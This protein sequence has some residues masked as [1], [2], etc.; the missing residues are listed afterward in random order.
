MPFRQ[1]D[2]LLQAMPGIGRHYISKYGTARRSFRL[3]ANRLGMAKAPIYVHWLSTYECNF[4]CLHCEADAGARRGVTLETGHILRAVKDMG[5]M[6]VRT[7]II[8]GGEPLLRGDIFEVFDAAKTAGIPNLSLATNGF[9]VQD[10]RDELKSAGL[11]TVH[12]SIDGPAETND[13]T[14]GK[15]DASR[16]AWQ[17]LAFFKKIGVRNRVLNTLVHRGNIQELNRFAATVF[18][19]PATAWNI[20]VPL[21]KGR[22]SRHTVMHLTDED[23]A[24]LFGFMLEAG[25]RFPV[26]MAETASFLGPL[27]RRLRPQPFFC[28]AGIETC[29]I[30]P[31]G[32]VLGCHVLYDNAYSEGNIKE[33][34][35]RAIWERRRG[36]FK[37]PELHERC[38]T[39]PQLPACRGGCMARRACDRPCLREVWEKTPFPA[40]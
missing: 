24:V 40:R 2:K 30:M 5:G 10:F 18:D 36:R 15:R 19:S 8:T 17:A 13:R 6:G 27:D 12:V 34:S 29:S 31:D 4:R 21:M 20:Q 9:L 22:A 38:R 11:S 25:K 3:L 35:L 33:V 28:G 7:L 16:R 32:D 39:C 26:Q 23:Y 1:I 37:A 14:R